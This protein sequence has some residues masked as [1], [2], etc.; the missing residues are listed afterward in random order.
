MIKLSLFNGYFIGGIP[1][2]FGQNHVERTRSLVISS[3]VCP[4][5]AVL[6]SGGSC[7]QLGIAD[8]QCRSYQRPGGDRF[9]GESGESTEDLPSLVNIEKNDGKSP[10]FM[11]KSTISM[12]IFNSYLYVYQRVTIRN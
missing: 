2:I 10:C 6:L 5:E 7:T 12:V 4:G 8:G 9:R 3:S 11:G 1:N